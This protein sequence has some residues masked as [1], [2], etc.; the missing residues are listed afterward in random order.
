MLDHALRWHCT[1]LAVTSSVT[2]AHTFKA[3]I[4]IAVEHAAGMHSTSSSTC[5]P[6]F[7]AI[8]CAP[9]LPSPTRG[10]IDSGSMF[11]VAPHGTPAAVHCACPMCSTIAAQA[12]N[13]VCANQRPTCV[14]RYNKQTLTVFHFPIT[15]T[16]FQ[17]L[18]GSIIGLLWFVA[19]GTKIDLS[20]PTVKAVLPLAGVHTL[21]NLLTNVSLGMVAVSFTHTIK[22]LEP[23]FSVIL[24]SMFLGAPVDPWV[25]A[26]LVPIIGGVAGA[27]MS[28]VSFNWPGF[29]SALG[30][31]ITFQSR[32]VF[33]KKFMTPDIKDRVRP[34]PSQPFHQQ[35][36]SDGPTLFCHHAADRVSA[37]SVCE[38]LTQC[39]VM[40]SSKTCT[41]QCVTWRTALKTCTG[42]SC[43]W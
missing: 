42:Q 6:F 27:S 43:S 31:N 33:S 38:P 22:A 7:C 23:M 25:V 17:F 20:K 2:N 40:H 5:A 9:C 3:S 19:T 11:L 1:H 4:A 28:E 15:I 13:A 29:I 35:L 8:A 10:D 37:R 39:C 21:G 14:C 16:A 41:A 34:L 36:A 18:I 30:S 24:S 32:N 26:S 12:L